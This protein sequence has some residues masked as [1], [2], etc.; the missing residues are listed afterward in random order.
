[1]GEQESAHS[2]GQMDRNLYT[3][4]TSF[5]RVKNSNSDFQIFMCLPVFIMTDG[6]VYIK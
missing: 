1:M 4:K 6:M 2:D 5:V 3:T